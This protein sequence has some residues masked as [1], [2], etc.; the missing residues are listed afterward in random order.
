MRFIENISLVVLVLCFGLF[1][2]CERNLGPAEVTIQIASRSPLAMSFDHLGRISYRQKESVVLVNNVRRIESTSIEV[3]GVFNAVVPSLAASATHTVNC[4]LLVVSGASEESDFQ[5]NY[6]AKTAD[7]GQ[8]LASDAS[9]EVLYFGNYVGLVDAF[10]FGGTIN[11]SVKPGARREFTLLGFNAEPSCSEVFTAFRDKS[12]LSKAFKLASSGVVDLL[13]GVGKT[14]EMALPAEV[15]AAN[16]YSDCVIPDPT[17]IYP[18]YET[19]VL[20]KPK[21]P[22]TTYRSFSVSQTSNYYCEP[23]EVSLYA[24]DP[25]TFRNIPATVADDEY[26]SISANADIIPTYESAAKCEEDPTDAD[27]AATSYFKITKNQIKAQRWFRQRR[28]GT[29]NLNLA[30][31]RADGSGIVNQPFYQFFDSATVFVDSIVPAR[32]VKNSCYEGIAMLRDLNGYAVAAP[33]SFELVNTY[34]PVNLVANFYASSG[35]CESDTNSNPNFAISVSQTQLT[36]YFKFTSDMITAI[37]YGLGVSGT[38]ATNAK[39]RVNVVSATSTAV[40]PGEFTNIKVFASSG[41]QNSPTVP[42]GKIDCYPLFVSLVRA[43]ETEYVQDST[44]TFSLLPLKVRVADLTG[45]NTSGYSLYSDSTCSSP[46]YPVNSTFNAAGTDVSPPG[47]DSTFYKLYL[48]PDNAATY[49]LRR[50]EFYYNDEPVG[51]YLFNLTGPNH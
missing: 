10:N 45:P 51:T 30:L 8:S 32:V 18:L 9:A 20:R 17:T 27:A 29:S 42:V 1:S 24:D 33:A 48:K 13:P 50:L 35:D 12:K 21:F 7:P 40:V 16:N 44:S 11:L 31:A 43:D 28:G 38:A 46:I 34:S 36:Y 15:D 19:A 25:Y 26:F 4:Y 23:I 49:G 39:S 47:A 2:A 3:K 6:C 14:I 37:D 22:F 41:M 5:R